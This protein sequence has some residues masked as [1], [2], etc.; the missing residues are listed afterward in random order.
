MICNSVFELMQAFPYSFINQRGEIIVHKEA[1]EYFNISKCED[2]LEIRCK[3]L[4]WLSRGAYKT[5]PFRRLNKN[6]EFNKF[7]LDGINSFLKVEFSTSD[8]VEIYTRLG[9]GVNRPLTI[10][11]IESGY[12]MDVLKREVE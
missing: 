6:L 3:V 7:M 8:M 12:D 5:S 9:N 2:D 1:N 11:F 4:E 10:K